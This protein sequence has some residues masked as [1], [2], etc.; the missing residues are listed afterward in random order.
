MLLLLGGA[1]VFEDN[2]EKEIR[3]LAWDKDN[4]TVTDAQKWIEEN[5][6]DCD[7]KKE[8]LQITVVISKHKL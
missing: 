1:N 2:D 7:F 8:Y 6:P 3:F 5:V 4:D